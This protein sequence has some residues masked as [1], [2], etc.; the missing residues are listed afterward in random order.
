VY[1]GSTPAAPAP[2]VEVNLLGSNYGNNNTGTS[3][4]FTKFPIETGSFADVESSYY[5]SVSLSGNTAAII[6]EQDL[7]RRRRLQEQAG[8]KVCYNISASPPVFDTI[9][10]LVGKDTLDISISG[11]AGAATGYKTRS[12]NPCQSTYNIFYTPDMTTT[13][14]SVIATG[15]YRKVSLSG[16]GLLAYD[17]NKDILQYTP[18]VGNVDLTQISTSGM[19]ITGSEPIY[20]NIHIALS[21]TSAAVTDVAGDLFYTYDIS[22]PRWQPIPGPKT[23]FALKEVSLAGKQLVVVDANT[24]AGSNNTWYTKDITTVVDSSSWINIQGMALR[25]VSISGPPANV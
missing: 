4:V 10:S 15:G 18:D 20:D 8:P 21:R 17:Y 22:N 6:P 3:N 2:F 12:S 16:T 14:F 23:T 25:A 9:D 1:Y 11:A 13:N 24:D 5:I 7:R 19:N